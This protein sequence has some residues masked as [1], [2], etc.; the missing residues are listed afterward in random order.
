MS[1]RRR[2]RAGAADAAP[3][4]P[5]VAAAEA[6]PTGAATPWAWLPALLVLVALAYQPA[7][8]GGLL[9]DDAAHVTRPELRSLAGLWRIWTELGATQQ[10]YP[11]LHSAFWVQHALWGDATTGYHLVSLAAHATAAWLLAL[12]LLRLGASA[13]GAGLAAVL[14]ALHPVHVESVAWISEQKNTL[15]AV[16]G[17]AA[18]L[19]YLRF[20]DTRHE[21]F[22]RAALVSFGL[23]LLTKSVTA[24]LAPALVVVAWW[25]RGRVDPRRDL[26][27][28]APFFALGGGA[29]LLTAWLERA[30]IGAEGAAFDLSA[31]ERLA[32]AGHAFWFHL[33]KLAWPFDLA[34]VYPRWDPSRLSLLPTCAAVAVALALF[35]VRARTRAPFAALAVYA[36][37][38]FPALGFFNVYPFRYSF[39]ADH[40]QYLASVAPLSLAAAAIAA[41]ARR[42][43]P[44]P[45]APALAGVLVAAPLAVLTWRQAHDYADAER[46]YRATLARNPAAWLAH[47]NLGLLLWGDGRLAEARRHL[48]E[49]LRLAPDVAEHR[50]NVGRL[51]LADGANAAA[52]PHLEAAVQLDPW[53]VSAH[54]NL[55]VALLR[56]GRAEE[57]IPR[58]E[59][60][61][62]RAPD[63]AE[64]RANLAN[65]HAVAG[66]TLAR[67]GRLEDAVRHLE[68]AIRLDPARPEPRGDLGIALQMLGRADEGLAQ[69]REAARLRPDDAAMRNNLGAALLALGRRE[70]AAAEF[71]AALRLAPDLAAARD[72][73]ARA[74]GAR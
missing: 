58:F 17:L 36:L 56:L 48:D 46:L 40:F 24:L 13:G 55:G 22:R 71:E 34:F 38:L 32:V 47:N 23:A 73:L 12:A 25:R 51:L 52:L 54:N 11:L 72:N 68:E 7:W 70:E 49:A 31:A 67:A 37:L 35:A 63:L 18:A 65:A 19:A 59:E 41:A 62:R 15:S 33:G 30:Q 45:L 43:W 5:R 61:L 74:S 66:G 60:A 57:A 1:G 14:F 3:E 29:G 26:W 21:R 42:A 2:R 27:P 6:S 28:L 8:H 10:Y 39:V 16:L 53:L 9:W 20:D 44:S 4:R 69:L 50:L 64:A